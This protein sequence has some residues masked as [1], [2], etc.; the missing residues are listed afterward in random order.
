MSESNRN[1]FILKD[2]YFMK[3]KAFTPKVAV[4]NARNVAANSLKS[5]KIGKTGLPKE[6]PLEVNDNR[7]I[8][9]LWKDKFE[10]DKAKDSVTIAW[11]N[12]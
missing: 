7:L 2:G 1:E 8:S 5:V 9:T 4:D 11:L 12:K 6:L 10:Y 3:I